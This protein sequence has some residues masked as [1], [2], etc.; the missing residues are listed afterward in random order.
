LIY[1]GDFQINLQGVR[2]VAMG[3]SGTGNPLDAATLFY[4]PAGLSL[5]GGFQVNAS[6][7]IYSPSNGYASSPTGNYINHTAPNTSMPFAFYA[8]GT[9]NE[10]SRLGFGVGVY[11]PFGRKLDWGTEWTGR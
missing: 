11:T 1:A 7:Y 5:L 8:G 2:Q 3:G 10:R 4:N 9:V 6:G